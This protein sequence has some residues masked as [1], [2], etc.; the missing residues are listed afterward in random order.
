MRPE[1]VEGHNRRF[2]QL[3]AHAPPRG[4]KEGTSCERRE[5]NIGSRAAVLRRNER[6]CFSSTSD[7]E[8]GGLPARL[9]EQLTNKGLASPTRGTAWG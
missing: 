4:K 3:S 5:S 2:D 6:T 1:L 9:R 8:V 7:D